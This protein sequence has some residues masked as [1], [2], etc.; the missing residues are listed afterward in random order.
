MPRMLSRSRSSL[1]I[2]LHRPPRYACVYCPGRALWQRC[3][4]SRSSC[5][6]VAASSF[7]PPSL[8][9]FRFKL[10]EMV[11][12]VVLGFFDVVEAEE[13][14]DSVVNRLLPFPISSLPA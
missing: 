2:L 5:A 3:E 13:L 9:R 12:S 14:S 10:L 11:L 4:S 6:S 7:S 1:R 8:A